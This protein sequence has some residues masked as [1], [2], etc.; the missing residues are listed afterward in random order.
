VTAAELGGDAV[1]VFYVDDYLPVYFE[2]AG[3]LLVTKPTAGWKANAYFIFD[4][5]S[6]TDFKFA[7]IDQSTNKLVLGRRV[8]SQWIVDAWT[9]LQIKF[10]TWYQLLV[11]VNGTTV[12]VLLN[13]TQAFT[14]TFAARIIE[15][16]AVGL[17]KGMIGVG[18]DNS[19]GMWDNMAVQILPPDI[20]Y[21]HTE[22]FTDDAGL[23]GGGARQGSWQ[24]TPDQTYAGTPDT[25]TQVATS[26]V[27]LR[28]TL[29]PYAYLELSARV[30]LQGAGIAGIVFDAYGPDDFKF[31]GLDLATGRVVIGHV[32]PRN[33]LVIDA[34]NARTLSAG[35]TYT[36]L[37]VLKGA[38]V[39]LQVNGGFGV[40]FGFN[41]DLI[42]G[43]F[44]TFTQG[45][46]AVFDD[47]RI[48][49]SAFLPADDGGNPPPPPPAQP[50]VSVADVQVLEGGPGT[51]ATVQVT[52][53]LSVPAVGGE[54]VSWRTVDGTAIAGVDYVAGSGTVMFAAGQ[55]SATIVVTIIGDSLVEGD[56][57]FTVVLS[58]AVGLSLG[59]A[60]ATVTIRDDDQPPPTPVV[61]ITAPVASTTEGS[62]T[63][64]TIVLTRTGDLS[65]ML[66]VNL[67]WNGTATASVDYTWTATGGTLAADR[68]T[69][70][71]AAGSSSMTITI[72]PVDDIAVEATESVIVQLAAGSGY[73]LGT[74]ASATVTIID[75]DAPPPPTLPTLSI[76]DV[77]V[78]EGNKGTTNAVLTISL[79][80][81]AT[82]DITVRVTTVDGTAKAKTDYK[83]LA[84][85]ITIKKGATTA[86]VTIQIVGDTVAEPTES[87]TVVLS[88]LTGQATLG[89]AVGTITIVDNDGKMLVASL[90]EQQVSDGAALSAGQLQ[91]LVEAALAAWAARGADPSVLAALS[92]VITDLGGTG[93]AEAVGTTI[94]LDATAAGWGW[95]VDP[96]P[97][98]H[99][100]FVRRG[101]VLVASAGS[102]ASGRLDLWTV[103][104]HEIGHA[105]GYRH[106]TFA[107]GSDLGRIMEGVL[108]P[109][110]RRSF[111]TP[112][113]GGQ[114]GRSLAHPSH[115]G[116]DVPPL[117]SLAPPAGPSTPGLPGVRHS[118][119]ARRW[120]R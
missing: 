32:T 5:H 11:A 76:T 46:S 95:Y 96:T 63:P 53:T 73:V 30:S 58:G 52:V 108:E 38:S 98:T 80:A 37:V 23:F 65:E 55:T 14:Y 74:P 120:D 64:A 113:R 24:V 105:L 49:S 7:G 27:E 66:T 43:R 45:T 85:T 71:F 106:D 114:P 92:F 97:G 57:T 28:G 15:G 9:P 83:A 40:S 101:G 22:P 93:V 41:S 107:P 84:T 33:G 19:R 119:P 62:T 35:T 1:A 87:F 2:V 117:T 100:G 21:D 79:S 88:N 70:T 104:L 12:T 81:P 69:A 116:G 51:T 82:S 31:A 61:T 34:A 17:N 54:T 90:P 77:T 36:L 29:P 111:V 91:P 39:S 109:G 99:D 78:T 3:S 42:D 68:A 59:R 89:K 16:E 44:G 25:P 47:Y 60:T 4:Y 75:N 50:A 20:D 18:S 112:P 110:L 103:L 10:D 86:T 118:V 6:P 72:H 102:E 115:H 56:E 94:S 8:G 13:G 26:F 67:G 48:R